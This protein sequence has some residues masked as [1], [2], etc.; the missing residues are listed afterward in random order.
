LLPAAF[1]LKV[2]KEVL[3]VESVLVE[4][5]RRRL[6]VEVNLVEDNAKL[7]PVGKR[8][9]TPRPTKRTGSMKTIR[10]EGGERGR[11]STMVQ[12]EMATKFHDRQISKFEDAMIYRTTVIVQTER[13]IF[14]ASSFYYQVQL[15]F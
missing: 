4:E 10:G 11:P 13:E 9:R 8:D 7:D 1:V 12:L 5:S 6:A 2:L 14:N 15:G 3:R